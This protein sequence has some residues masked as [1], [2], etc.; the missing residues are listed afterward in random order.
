MMKIGL[1]DWTHDTGISQSP[2]ERSR[3]WSEYWVTTVNCCWYSDQKTALA[4]NSGMKANTRD[5]SSA[6]MPLFRMTT[7]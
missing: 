6:V 7:K 3:R 4:M 1:I 2:N 5:R